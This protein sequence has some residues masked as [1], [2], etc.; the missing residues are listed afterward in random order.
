MPRNAPRED[1]RGTGAFASAKEAVS[2]ARILPIP[3]APKLDASQIAAA[4]GGRPSGPQWVA[5][6]PA[7]EDRNPSLSIREA[8]GKILVHCHA[9]CPQEAV[10]EA[11]RC[12]GLWP[13]RRREW[14]PREE[15]LRRL[16]ARREAEREARKL[17]EWRREQLGLLT[18]LRNLYWDL[19]RVA[20]G[21]LA[22]R[23][24][25]CTVWDDPRTLKALRIIG[26]HLGDRFALAIECLERLAPAQ[27]AELRNR[28]QVD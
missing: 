7:H 17:A 23:Q 24:G 12:R 11:L 5:R 9:G 13:E 28:L 15:Y 4:L 16:R 22:S 6:C 10:V 26:E 20:E 2:M 27:V 18:R 19:E 25:R 21:W 3:S 8:G 1:Q 14:L